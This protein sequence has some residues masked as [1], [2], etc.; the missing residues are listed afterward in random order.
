[1]AQVAEYFIGIW[2]GNDGRTMGARLFGLNRLLFFARR[3]KKWDQ[4]V[5]ESPEIAARVEKLARQ[6]CARKTKTKVAA[7]Q[8]KRPK[9]NAGLLLDL[10][11]DD[12][13]RYAW[14]ATDAALTAAARGTIVLGRTPDGLRRG[15]FKD[16]RRSTVR[17]LDG[18]GLLEVR[19]GDL[20]GKALDSTRRWFD[21]WD[22]WV[23]H[24]EA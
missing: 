14:Y 3:T 15:R 16:G 13:E 24:L 17:A 6:I 9:W 20:T 7:E 11:R 22:E 18:G 2:F 21:S 19:R 23:A 8:F 12:E 10:I 1:M 4:I 5:A